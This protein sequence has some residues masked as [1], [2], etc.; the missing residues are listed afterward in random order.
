MAGVTLKFPMKTSLI[1]WHH[2]IGA[3]EHSQ[4]WSQ[5]NPKTGQEFVAIFVDG[6]LFKK[7]LNYQSRNCERYVQGGPKKRL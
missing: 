3:N 7:Q 6:K 5:Q 2:F 1:Q 4:Q